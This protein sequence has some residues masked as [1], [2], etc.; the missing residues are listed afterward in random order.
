MQEWN[1]TYYFG[2]TN[3]SNNMGLIAFYATFSGIFIILFK[4]KNQGFSLLKNIPYGLSV[5]I[6]LSVLFQ[7]GSRTPPVALISAIIFYIAYLIFS[8]NIKFRYVIIS[9]ISFGVTYSYF[10]KE[11]F[12]EFI[13]SKFRATSSAGDLLSGRGV[14]WSQV[15]K[16]AMLFGH[17]E[18]YFENKLR[19]ASH[20]IFI[21]I[22]GEYGLITVVFLVYL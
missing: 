13:L 5:I 9:F 15:M 16:E 22:L 14:I 19:I 8:N 17:G 12:E 21:Q 7:T 6:S 20:N 18:S 10:L 4:S 2:V 1:T 3:N 11:L